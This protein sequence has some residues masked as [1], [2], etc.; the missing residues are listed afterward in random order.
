M[1]LIS[2]ERYQQMWP[3]EECAPAEPWP[4]TTQ[5]AIELSSEN[6]DPRWQWILRKHEI[7]IGR[8]FGVQEYQKRV[9]DILSSYRFG[10]E[11]KKKPERYFA[12]VGGR[13]RKFG[14]LS[15]KF[16]ALVNDWEDAHLG[17]STTDYNHVAYA[18]I[19]GIGPQAVPLLLKKLEDGDGDWIYALKCITG[20][21]ADTPDMHGNADKVISAWLKWGRRHV[22]KYGRE[23][24]R[25]ESPKGQALQGEEIYSTTVRAYPHRK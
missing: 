25:I 1:R 14:S 5:R 3:D 21:E 24:Q 8:R 15:A 13:K 23:E 17:R 6:E 4:K 18:Q 11:C 10:V 2:K 7:P 19:I 16:H 22:K 9:R 12:F 20:E